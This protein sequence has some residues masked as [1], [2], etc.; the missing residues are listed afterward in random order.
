VTSRT[1]RSPCVPRVG[2]VEFIKGTIEFR[3]GTVK[4]RS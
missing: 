1:A 3:K 2:A 4:E